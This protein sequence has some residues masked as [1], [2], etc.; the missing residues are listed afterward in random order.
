MNTAIFYAYLKEIGCRLLVVKIKYQKLIVLS[1]C[2]IYQ[3]KHTMDYNSQNVN[4]EVDTELVWNSL[5]FRPLLLPS[6][7]NTNNKKT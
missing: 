3:T 4:N 2:G 1:E 7:N 6:V 5:I